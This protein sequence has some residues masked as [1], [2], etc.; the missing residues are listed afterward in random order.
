M[1]GAPALVLSGL[2][3]AIYGMA[4]GLLVGKAGRRLVAYV[5]VAALG[6]MAGF[7]AS[8]ALHLSPYVIG[9]I[10]IVESSIIS[11]VA[12]SIAYGVRL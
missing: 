1:P 5:V 9:D 3:S 11:L 10:P 8:D 6:F 7:P 2:L 12:M 4:Y